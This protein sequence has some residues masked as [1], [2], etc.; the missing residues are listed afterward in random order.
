MLILPGGVTMEFIPIPPG[1][2]LMGS[3]E[4]EPG[5][6]S[7]EGPQHQVTIAYPFWLGKYPVTQAQWRAVMGTSVMDQRN[8][9][10]AG[11]ID[12]YR[13]Y[14]LAGEGPDLPMYYVSW[15]E[16]QKFIQKV[17]ALGVGAFRLPSE[18]EWEYACRAGTQTRYYCGDS[19]VKLKDYAWLDTNSVRQTHPVGQK[20][21]NAW[22]LHD[23][24]GNVWEWCQDY[25]HDTYAGAPLDGTAWE[26]P[27]VQYRMKRG[28]SWVNYPLGCRAAYR[29]SLTPDSRLNIVG[30]RLA[31]T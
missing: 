5:R 9:T 16:C 2:F 11:V 12:P 10:K 22:G 20:L 13:T 1:T 19:D 17:N 7:K 18:A 26:T 6:E 21:P 4:N 30:F 24:H 25:W 23:M 8:M 27:A 29:F 15:I 14:D 3:P 31:R 28:G